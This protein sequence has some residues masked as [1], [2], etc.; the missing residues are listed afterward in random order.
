MLAPEN[1]YDTLANAAASDNASLLGLGTGS[2]S[3]SRSLSSPYHCQAGE[4]IRTI[5]KKKRKVEQ[6]ELLYV[7][8]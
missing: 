3:N 6:T 7:L 4:D 5:G 8:P 1:I 2:G